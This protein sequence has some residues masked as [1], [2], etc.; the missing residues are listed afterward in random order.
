MIFE[1]IRSHCDMHEREGN[2]SGHGPPDYVSP[3]SMKLCGVPSEN[4][5]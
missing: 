1:Y 4:M 3:S 2:T 5:T